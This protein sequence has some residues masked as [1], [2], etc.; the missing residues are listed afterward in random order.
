MILGHSENFLEIGLLLHVVGRLNVR[1]EAGKCV[2][3]G[4]FQLGDID[5]EL[6]EIAVLHAIRCRDQDQDMVQKP[7]ALWSLRLASG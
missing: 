6:L 3:G 4:I 1:K 5:V 2:P 7:D